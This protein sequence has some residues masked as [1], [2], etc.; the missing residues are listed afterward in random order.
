[1]K[2]VLI[3]G[4]TGYI[5]KL[6]EEHLSESGCS[7]KILT[8]NP[9]RENHV[10]WNPESGKI[11]REKCEDVQV[12]INL[13]GEG[14]DKKRWTEKQKKLLADSRIEVTKKLFELRSSFPV[15]EHYISA[16]GITAYG[17]D[18]GVYEHRETD[19]YGDDFLSKLVERWEAAADLF[20]PVVIVSKL[21]I[22][23]V[24]E[25]GK[26][27]LKKMSIPVRLGLGSPLG[28]GK[29]QIPWVH[30]SDLVRIFEFVIITEAEGTFNTSANN[31]SNEDLTKAI[32]RSMNK[33]IWMPNVPGFVLKIL[34]GQMSEMILSGAK[35]SNE[36]LKQKGF[37][38]AKTAIDDVLR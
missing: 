25:Q 9:V 28:S 18:E 19:E 24:L 26:G 10:F 6:L 31:I 13:C 8:R 36:K 14:I 21:R 37:V 4:G 20:K 23:V 7:V 3:A 12:L 17:F 33:K 27:A 5:G 35:A 11:D 22:A 32:A 38:F 34:L 1:M 2:T 29:Q 30:I 15:L 16:S